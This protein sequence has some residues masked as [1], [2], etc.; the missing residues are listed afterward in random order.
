MRCRAP[1]RMRKIARE[2]AAVFGETPFD[3]YLFVY[4][5]EADGVDRLGRQR[6]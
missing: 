1:G 4:L 3:R 5:L 2:S 6:Q